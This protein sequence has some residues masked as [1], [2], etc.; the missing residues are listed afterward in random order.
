MKF[1]HLIHLVSILILLPAPTLSFSGVKEIT[2]N[3]VLW[4]VKRTRESLTLKDK[5]LKGREACPGYNGNSKSFCF[6]VFLKKNEIRFSVDVVLWL[7]L[8]IMAAS[9]DKEEKNLSIDAAK[10][11]MLEN[12][13]VILER[14][15]LKNFY[16]AQFPP[17]V[18]ADLLRRTEEE[19]L[20]K[21][22][23]K[24]LNTIESEFKN[25]PPAQ[26]SRI[27]MY[28]RRLAVVQLRSWVFKTSATAK[29]K[30]R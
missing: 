30:A 28:R 7:N 5:I 18:E 20:N 19:E 26:A 14:V 22:K 6:N 21:F 29:S 11:W 23:Q 17:G 25:F 2:P 24:M 8:A 9:A 10:V 16:L 15:D 3:Y 4:V 12:T 1:R 13:M 27:S